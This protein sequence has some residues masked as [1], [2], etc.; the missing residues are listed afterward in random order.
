[1]D[2]IMM[3]TEQTY[4]KDLTRYLCQ[5]YPVPHDGSRYTPSEDDKK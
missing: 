5:G 3:P 1:V 4:I 2:T